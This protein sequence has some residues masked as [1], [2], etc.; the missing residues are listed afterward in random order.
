MTSW[1]TLG[2]VVAGAALVGTAGSAQA[3]RNAG[4]HASVSWSASEAKHDLCSAPS[5]ATVYVRVSGVESFQGATVALHWAPV[6]REGCFERAGDLLPREARNTCALNRGSSSVSVERD[7]ASHYTL[8]WRNSEC[9]TACDDGV[10]LHVRYDR[11]LCDGDT[12]CFGLSSVT[13]VDCD[14]AEDEA[15][16]SEKDRQLT[17]CGTTCALLDTHADVERSTWGKIKSLYSP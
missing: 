10:I 5:S 17:I 12:G 2:C 1:R 3:G 8:S 16:L 7:D 4:A 15:L 14:G 11:S 13:L 6:A 9:F